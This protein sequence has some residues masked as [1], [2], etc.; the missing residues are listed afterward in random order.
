MKPLVSVCM[1]IYNTSSY[2]QECIDSI[3]SQSFSDFELLI[4][5]DG[6]T[7]N[8]CDIVCSYNDPR[9]RLIK[10]NH[11]YIGSLNLLL[12]EARGKYIARMDS[13]DL[14]YQ[15]RL[16]V[17][18]DYMESHS[19]ISILASSAVYMDSKE[20]LCEYSDCTVIT[21][22]DLLCYNPIIH[23]TTFMRTNMLRKFDLKYEDGYKYAEDYRLWTEC[24][25]CQLKIAIIPFVGIE[26][27][28]NENQITQK[29]SRSVHKSANRVK[30]SFARW[31]CLQSNK[32]YKHPQIKD[33]GKLLTVIIPFLNEGIEVVETVKSL[34]SMV[35]DDVDIIIVNDCST[36]GL[37][38][39]SMLSAYG[40]YYVLNR[41]RKGV[42]ASRDFGIE[43]CKTPYFLLLDAHMRVY[44]ERWLR[45]ITDLLMRNDRQLLCAQTKQLWK[46]DTG[47]IIELKDVAPVYGAY[48]TFEK[49][50]LSPGIE[51][52]YLERDTSE[53]TQP[54]ACVLGAGYAASRRYW[55][56]LR[57][58][59]GLELYGCDEVYISLKV[60]SE[61]GRCLLLKEHS[62]GHIYRDKAPYQI[63]QCSFVYNYLIIAYI[64]FP[65]VMWYWILSCCQIARP[66]DFMEAWILFKKNKRKLY[67]LKIY[68][69]QIATASLQKV[70]KMNLLMSEQHIDNF[71]DRINV[72][73]KIFSN[74]LEKT[75]SN[76]GIIDGKMA[77]LI[78]MSLWDQDGSKGTI[79]IRHELFD[80]LKQAI[81]LKQM[82]CNFRNGLCGVG[83][84]LLYL[85][86]NSLID[87][88][89]ES[90]LNQIDLDIQAVDIT[91]IS[92]K[93][94][95]YGTSGIM[96]YFVCRQ[97]YNRHKG[98]STKFS[99]YFASAIIKEGK[100]LLK[101][102]NEHIALYYSHILKSMNDIEFIND[103]TPQ[104]CDW[105]NFPI[106]NPTN[107]RYWT[108]SMDNG[109]L[110]YTIPAFKIKEP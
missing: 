21:E 28:R 2:L 91:Q 59:E 51:W 69:S 38:Y 37:D 35:H 110:G 55:T 97:L 98:L 78:W 94:L 32:L 14:M 63:T 100:M 72:A 103:F 87:D 67:S 40:V 65:T 85:Y 49:G 18:F 93:S 54:I 73:D 22:Q 3:L 33:S 101:S 56:H 107:P 108:F 84:G 44:N 30:C 104:L 76:Y 26:Y 62:F 11:D 77:A 86:A 79:Q 92:N 66:S 36:D 34:R 80:E 90:L 109:C 70:I 29:H 48:A 88:I 52:N 99:D 53:V 27:R 74:V 57:G 41:K 7:D 95:Y 96:A 31:L 83:W 102:S 20:P 23:P 43:L 61:G 39:Q 5:D 19:E 46:D 68:H 58:L 25:K 89:D 16:R 1:S 47:K 60:W 45:D 24:V 42:A 105:I 6:S 50:Q 15:N 106:T 75:S 64:L 9:I 71:A 12:K 81:L 8:S 10:N 13:D 4:V 17:Q 82:P